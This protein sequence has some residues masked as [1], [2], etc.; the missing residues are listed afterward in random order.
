M[1]AEASPKNP[2]TFL[3]ID[4]NHVG[5]RIDNF[6]IT[7]LKGLPKSHL[8]RVL[9]KGEVRVNK[10]RI[11]PEYRLQLGDMVRVP[12]L[13][14]STQSNAPAKPS[15]NAQQLLTTRVLYEDKNL[16][17]INKPSGMAVHGGSGVS[18]G[19]IEILRAMRPQE[20]FLEL[21]HRLDRDTS[22]CLMLAKK[23]SV[24]KELHELLRSGNMEKKYWALV[25]GYWPKHLHIVDA[26]LKKYE[27][28]CGE[29][30]VNVDQEGKAAVTEFRVLQ[31]FENTT[32]LEATLQ[33]GRTHQIRVHA[34][35]AGYPLAGD[36]KYGDKDFNKNMRAYGCKRLFLHAV[37]LS[38]VLPTTGQRVS[39]SSEVDDSLKICLE[40]LS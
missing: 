36:D 8:Y 21:V 23:A 30:M 26:P 9:R 15:Q 22:G 1:N 10:K 37:S 6:L 16:L 13:R 39:V 29:R 2:V 17:I 18:L 35:H 33:T 34:L 5:Q 28:R 12:P 31:R 32:L 11:K 38:F 14:L 3:T 40:K 24:L 4:D 27:L 25:K 19:V 20:K 7:R